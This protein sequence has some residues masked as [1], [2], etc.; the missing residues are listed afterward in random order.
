MYHLGGLTDRTLAGLLRPHVIGYDVSGVIV[1]C[2]Q[3]ASKFR[4]GDEVFGMLPHDNNG[5]LAE[6]AAS[7]VQ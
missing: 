6:Y 3:G 2:G 7:L 5:S 1:A 4:V